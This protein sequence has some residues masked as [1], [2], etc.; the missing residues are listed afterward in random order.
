MNRQETF[1][2]IFNAGISYDRYV[3]LT[4]KD[5]VKDRMLGHLEATDE[6]I[7]NMDPH[8]LE[9][10]NRKMKVL[11][12][13]ENWCGDCANAIPVISKLAESMENWGFVIASK[14]AFEEEFPLFYSTAGR[15]KIP[16]IIF[17][18]ED[19]DEISRWVERPTRSYRL[20]ADLQ[21]QKLP[22][23]EYIARY[24]SFPELKVPSLTDEILKE[25]IETADRATAMI[26]IL[27]TKRR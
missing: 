23:E 19:G 25:L 26:Q 11:C 22:K 3:E 13:G 5:R 12:I 4:L 17:A 1:L 21:A 16:V 18:D 20:L 2:K 7:K 27:P 15:Q 6:L 14:T 10:L 8:K 9:R 24:K